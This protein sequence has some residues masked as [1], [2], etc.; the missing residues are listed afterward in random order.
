[1]V[2]LTGCAKLLGLDET[3]FVPDDALPAACVGPMPT[4]AAT[5]GR[6]VCGQLFTVGATAGM[7]LRANAPT[8]LACAVGGTGP[9]ALAVAAQTTADLF[10]GATTSMPGT[11]DDCG[12]YAINDTDA[13]A[14]DIA[15]VVSGS[16]AVTTPEL[17]LARPT[18]AGQ[19]DTFDLVTVATADQATWTTQITGI[20]TDGYLVLY[21][22][23]NLPRVGEQVAI[24]GDNPVGTSPSMTDAWAG[25]FGDVGFG[26]L[27]PAETETATGGTAIFVPNQSGAF[28]LQ[29]FRAGH[30]CTV[31]GVQTVGSALVVVT[32]PDC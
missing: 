29:G 3:Q 20:L 11:I 24:N 28:D 16:N 15:V 13:T 19:I 5:T 21:E 31:S 7:P 2:L 22:A 9:C 12:R 4:C 1:M 14:A 17:L 8:G 10:S 32:I 25:Y 6:S 27:M 30:R 18:T 26:M 23:S